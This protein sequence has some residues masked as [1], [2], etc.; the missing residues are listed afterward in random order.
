MSSTTRTAAALDSLPLAPGALPVAGHL[1][2]L[3]RDPLSFMTAPAGYGEL[4]RIRLGPRT[5]VVICSP[6]LALRALR[7]DRTFDKIGGIFDQTRSV[8]G[9]GLSNCPHHLHRRQ[10]R[11]LQPT[12]HRFRMPGYAQTMTGLIDETTRTW[13]DGQVLDVLPETR[14][15]GSRVLAACMFPEAALMSTQMT[16]LTDAFDA[17]LRG[18]LRKVLLPAWATNLP[19]LA[20]RRFQRAVDHLRQT[21][22][23]AVEHRRSNDRDHGDLLSAMLAARDEETPGGAQTALTET[24]LIDNVVTFVI[25]GTD[26]SAISLAWALYLLAQHPDVA[27]HLRTEVDTVLGGRPARYDD[28]P[29]LPFTGDVINEALRCYPPAWITTRTT[30]VDTHLGGHQLPQG[31]VLGFCVPLLQRHPGQFP[32]HPERFDPDRRSAQPAPPRP[33]TPCSPSAAA[34]ANASATSSPAA[35][36]PSPWPPSPAAGDW[37]SCPTTPRPYPPDQ[38]C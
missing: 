17:V 26:T 33:A 18:V 38:A 28:L 29:R 27:D 35:S 1:L 30:A 32:D 9:D 14:A 21:A 34:P 31:T 6:D 19:L 7:D 8:L 24:E 22:Q 5:M 36:S 16:R 13:Q 25:A 37:S 10:R 12:F 11:L 3:L 20:N 23:T 4:V 15:L 2:P